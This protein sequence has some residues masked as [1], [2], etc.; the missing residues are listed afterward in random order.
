MN[1]DGE[2]AIRVRNKAD[3]PGQHDDKLAVGN[4]LQVS[5]QIIDELFS[6]LAV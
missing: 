6:L 4:D 3:V 1:L 2:A 5:R